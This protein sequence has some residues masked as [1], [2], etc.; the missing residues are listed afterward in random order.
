[1]NPE[2][3]VELRNINKIFHT[4]HFLTRD[5]ETDK[6]R[7]YHKKTVHAVNDVSLGVRPGEVFGLLGPLALVLAM[8]GVGLWA[9][10]EAESQASST[11]TRQ[12]LDGAPP[13]PAFREAG[14]IR[15]AAEEMGSG[16]QV[17]L[18]G[19]R[20]DP[21]PLDESPVLGGSA[22]ARLSRIGEKGKLPFSPI[23]LP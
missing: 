13:Y 2:Y 19:F 4:R 17:F 12:N 23:L 20:A 5:E 3:A 7:I 16:A 9:W 1:M 18:A 21:E 14:S 22:P 15:L 6:R 11:L 10:Y 8:A